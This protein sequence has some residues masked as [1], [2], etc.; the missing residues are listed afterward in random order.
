MKPDTFKG[1]VVGLI[2]GLLLGVFVARPWIIDAV[3]DRAIQKM[4]IEPTE[5]IPDEVQSVK[6][7]AKLKMKLLVEPVQLS[8]ADKYCLAKNIYHEAGVEEWDGKIAVGQVTMQ[9]IGKRNWGDTV[10]EVVY[11]RKQFSWTN[12]AALRKEVPKGP[13][14]EESKR[15]ARAVI[16]GERVPE[17]TASLFYH[18]EYIS[19]PAWASADYKV[20]QLGQHIFYTNDR[21]K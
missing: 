1:F 8:T 2:L 9:R 10:C 13:L 3:A 20:A 7:P 12:D 5:E 18:A 6:P 16:K 4:T 14:W 15:A 19:D 21:K 11:K 17:L